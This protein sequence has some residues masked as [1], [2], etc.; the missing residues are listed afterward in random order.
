[1]TIFYLKIKYKIIPFKKS[2]QDYLIIKKNIIID[3]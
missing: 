2:I 1:M 3:K